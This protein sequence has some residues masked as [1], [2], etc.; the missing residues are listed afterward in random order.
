MANALCLVLEALRHMM[1]KPMNYLPWHRPKNKKRVVV[2]VIGDLILDEYLEGEVSRISPE[3]PVPILLVKNTRHTGGGAANVARNVHLAGGDARLF[4]VLGADD[5]ARALS[6]ILSDDGIN[7]ANLI[8]DSLRPTIKK[9]RAT[10]AHNQLIRIDWEKVTPISPALQQELL[11]RIQK[12]ASDAILLSDYGKGCLA[13]SFLRSVIEHAAQKNIPVIIDPKGRDYTPY[14]GC[15][16]ITPNRKEACEALGLDPSESPPP[17]EL[18]ALLQE[19]YD[20]R[21]ILVT[22]GAEG[23]Y[24]HPERGAGLTPIHLPAHSREVFDVSGAGDTVAAIMALSLAAGAKMDDAMTLAN[25]A[26]GRVIE[27]WGTQPI[28]KNELIEAMKRFHLMRDEPVTSSLY[29]ISDR[30]T[31]RLAIGKPGE[32]S[33]SVVF[34]NGCFDI[35]HAGHVSYLERAKAKGDIL[36]VGINSDASVRALKGAS[37]P[38]VP[39][40]QRMRILA[41]LSCIDYIVPFDEDTPADLITTLVPDVLVKGADYSIENIVG[42]EIVTAHGGKVEVI[43]FIEGIST[44]NIV[45]KIRADLRAAVE[46]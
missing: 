19:K 13:A 6:R 14:R 3:A 31:V 1:Y 39:E 7:T 45:D 17:D 33:R 37:R 32:R 42:A 38:I 8:I 2:A 16:M 25:V 30:E 40:D 4:G 11:A 28:E 5:S 18:G 43:D 23:M 12:T 20:L 21:H 15:F 44:T 26:A 10:S 27:K 46:S 36:V 22:L 29:K 41:A 35:L 9:T 34:T 24:F